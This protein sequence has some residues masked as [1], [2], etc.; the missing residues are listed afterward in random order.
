M[1]RAGLEQKNGRGVLLG[2]GAVRDS[3]CNRSSGCCSK[4][5]MDYVISRPFTAQLQ[6][7]KH[8]REHFIVQKAGLMQ[9]RANITGVEF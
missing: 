9:H 4:K 2:M 7:L 6:A 1:P 8:F 3:S 5:R